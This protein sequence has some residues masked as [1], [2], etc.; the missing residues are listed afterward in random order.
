[1]NLGQNGLEEAG[2]DQGNCRRR[3]QWEWREVG[4]CEDV[5]ELGFSRI[6]WV[7]EQDSRLV[8]RAAE[9]MTEPFIK[10]GRQEEKQFVGF[11]FFSRKI[12]PELTSANPPLFTEEDWP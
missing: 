8:A 4:T 12:S 10:M 11:F 3:R 1:M 2:A 7:R 6:D 5:Q 9:Q